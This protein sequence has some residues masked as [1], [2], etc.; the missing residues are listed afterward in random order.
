MN[1]N[2]FSLFGGH[3]LAKSFQARDDFFKQPHDIRPGRPKYSLV[4]KKDHL[5]HMFVSDRQISMNEREVL[6][7]PQQ[8]LAAAQT[9]ERQPSP[10]SVVLHEIRQ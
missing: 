3:T 1:V 10:E 7:C 8:I 2:T 9:R 5:G 6:S 4:D